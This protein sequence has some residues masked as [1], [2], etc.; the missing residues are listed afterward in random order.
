[1]RCVLMTLHPLKLNGSLCV[2]ESV[3]DETLPLKTCEPNVALA[4]PPSHGKSSRPGPCR[5]FS[6]NE[7]VGLDGR[8]LVTVIVAVQR[9]ALPVRPSVVD[10]TGFVKPF[11]PTGVVPNGS[12]VDVVVPETVPCSAVL[13]RCA[14]ALL[15]LALALGAGA[16]SASSGT[17]D[18]GAPEGGALAGVAAAFFVE[19]T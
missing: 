6:L 7:H 16:V 17:P 3:V 13:V 14:A 11:V 19:S 2:S 10:G 15:A 5:T 18:E 8:K 4:E 1:M 12:R 9:C